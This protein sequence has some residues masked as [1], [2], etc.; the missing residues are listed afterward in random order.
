MRAGQGKLS[1]H[2]SRVSRF[3]QALLQLM[4]INMIVPAANRHPAVYSHRI[5]PRLTR[6]GGKIPAVIN[7]AQTATHHVGT[8]HAQA[9]ARAIVAAHTPDLPHGAATALMAWKNS[10]AVVRRQIQLGPHS[11]DDI[12][13]DH[14]LP[15]SIVPELRAKF[16]NLRPEPAAVNLA[17]GNRIGSGEAEL[18][19]RW[20]RRGLLSTAG[21]HAVEAIQRGAP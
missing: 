14:V 5:A 17:K 15:I 16:F 8:A 11:G 6:A 10:A 2:R 7:T 3:S 13:I 4:C 21:L 18:A 19:R 1:I 12:H 9:D 20:H